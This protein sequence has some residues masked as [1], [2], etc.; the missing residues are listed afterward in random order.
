MLATELQ[1]SFDFDWI[2]SLQWNRNKW[3][4]AYS[5]YICIDIVLCQ[6]PSVWFRINGAFFFSSFN[7][8]ACVWLIFSASL[9]VYIL[10]SKTSTWVFFIRVAVHLIISFKSVLSG[11]NSFISW[12]NK[13]KNKTILIR[14]AMLKLN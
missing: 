13:I 8:I 4:T 11:L 12:W 5:L 1:D 6:S 3:K 7:R 10:F 14:L 9:S 2:C